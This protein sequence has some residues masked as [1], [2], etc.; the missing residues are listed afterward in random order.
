MGTQKAQFCMVGF[1]LRALQVRLKRKPSSV[2]RRR[3]DKLINLKPKDTCK[4]SREAKRQLY[5]C[6]AFQAEEVT[7]PGQVQG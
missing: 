2:V 3:T 1:L 6:R 7:E 4:G 5:Q